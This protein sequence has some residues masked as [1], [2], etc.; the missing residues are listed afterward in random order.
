MDLRLKV[1]AVLVFVL[2]L[3]VLFIYFLTGE[4]FAPWFVV[5]LIFLFSFFFVVRIAQKQRRNR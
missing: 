3:V 4:V 1:M 2:L 5:V